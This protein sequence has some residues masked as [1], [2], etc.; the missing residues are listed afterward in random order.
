M[1][2]V[3]EKGPVA[4]KLY[5]PRGQWAEASHRPHYQPDHGRREYIWLFG[6]L[7]PHTGEGLLYYGRRR[8]SASFTV[9]MDQVDRWLPE[10]EF[11]V[12]ID[13]LS[14]HAS[15]ATLL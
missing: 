9:F 8:D 13:N 10:G 12:G 6:A 14:L 1:I 4:A 15:V 7:H 2:C 11:H 3:D 5:P